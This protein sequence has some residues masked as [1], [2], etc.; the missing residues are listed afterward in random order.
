MNLHGC[1][2]DPKSSVLYDK[3]FQMSFCG[4]IIWYRVAI[5]TPPVGFNEDCILRKDDVNACELG[6]GLLE[7][8]L[9]SEIKELIDG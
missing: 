9:V 1:P 8:C 2:L 6:L 5:Q 7:A 3:V 4:H